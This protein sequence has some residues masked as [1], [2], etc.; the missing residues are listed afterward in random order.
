M[1]IKSVSC[2]Q[3]AGIRDRSVS[4]EDGMNVIY[5][6]N[7]SGKSTLVNLISRT[8]FQNAKV[9]G[10]K[11]KTFVEAFFPSS[12]KGSTIELKDIDGKISFETE[13]GT[14]ILSK[15]W[16]SE[17]SCKLNT[18]DGI[19]KKQSTIDE[20]LRE[21]LVYGEGL[22]ND[23]IFSAQSSAAETL[24]KTLDSKDSSDSKR[25]IADAVSQAF[26]EGDGPSM[27][28]IADAIHKKIEAIEGS[29]WDA[30]A[31]APVRKKQAGRWSNG[32]GE[33]LEAFYKVEDAKEVLEKLSRLEADVE[34]AMRE[35]ALKDSETQEAKKAVESFE[36]FANLLAVQSMKKKEIARNEEELQKIEKVLTE[37]PQRSEALE[38]AKKLN[39]EKR[40]LELTEKY[41]G[42]KRIADSIKQLQNELDD[43]Y[44]PSEIEIRQ[45]KS[46]QREL[47]VLESKLSAMDLKA[48][49]KM[50][51]DSTVSITSL[52]TGD[53]LDIEDG[54]AEITEAVKITVPGVMEMQLMPTDIDAADVGKKIAQRKRFIN[55]L[56]DKYD[57]ICID[58]LEQKKIELES[59][60]RSLENEKSRLEFT[61][62]D[63]SFDALEAEAALINGQ[64]RTKE[65][66]N[67][68]IA[69]VCNGEAISAFISGKEV[70]IEKFAEEYGSIN[71]LKGK[72]FDLQR[73]L[74]RT[75]ESV[76]CTED[77]PA[78]YRSVSDPEMYRETLKKIYEQKQALRED[79]LTRKAAALKSLETYKDGLHGDPSEDLVRAETVFDET[80]T[81]LA[82][83]KHIQ[84]I[85]NA[86]RENVRNNPMEGLAQSFTNY[87]SLI[88]GGR[89]S[90]EF[91]DGE[92][93]D[94]NIYSGNNLLDYKKLSEGTKETVS[95]AFRLAV[96]DHLFPDGGGVIVFD[97]PFANM[98]AERTAQSCELIK[99]C[100]EK[101]QVLFLTCKEEYT[102]M[103]DG[104]VIRI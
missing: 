59:K 60:E 19:I 26:S 78:E 51:G 62:G 36:A 69:A 6:K 102:E 2:E 14:Y 49:I 92:K 54:A 76:S 9:D 52:L 53:S 47:T 88:S 103:F 43:A 100:A 55:D 1:K 83:W 63:I 68:D 22:Y 97:D 96:L 29:H 75:K 67:G 86:E 32:R 89:V 90:S 20:M 84:K 3:F 81:L 42:A 65:E 35:F 66:V 31:D 13:S 24:M 10:R 73:E 58:E 87:L 64:F 15:E 48:V 74:M 91:P 61:L 8:L 99:E 30:E 33:I 21:A 45:V 37:W 18:P 93:L 57:V 71:E 34:N 82:H 23:M 25:V 101:H 94:M 17:P 46:A 79:A 50:L 27:D 104:N 85:F 80:K 28:V 56:F 12:R 11:D 4:F 40:N 39:T 72:A 77:I 7:E 44:C 41:V 95:L 5:G 38:K 16:G 98:D 70:L